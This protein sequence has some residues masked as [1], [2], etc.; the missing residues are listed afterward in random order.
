[1]L[2]TDLCYPKKEGGLGLKDLEVWNHA[3]MLQHVWN[4]FARLGSIW[5]AWIKENILKNKSFWDI[6]ISQ[7]SS[8]CWRKLLTLRVLAKHFLKFDV[9]MGK[10]FT[11]G[12]T[13]GTF[14]EYCS[15]L[16]VSELS[17]MLRVD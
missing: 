16:M 15:I 12:W 13:I 3:S 14:V 17:T 1:L 7:N 11:C 8:W 5:V 9:G 6:G 4:L 10:T 2:W